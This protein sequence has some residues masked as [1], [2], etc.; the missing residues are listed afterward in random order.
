VPL[1]LA[2][3]LTIHKAQ[4]ATLFFVK[5]DLGGKLSHGQTYVVL[6]RASPKRDLQIV[7]FSPAAI[8]VDV[9]VSQFYESLDS[10]LTCKHFLNNCPGT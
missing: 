9:L 3:A 5:V 8:K 7:K 4:G 1:K 6:G 2:W 10:F